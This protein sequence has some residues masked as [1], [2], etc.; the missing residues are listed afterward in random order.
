MCTAAPQVQQA[1]CEPNCCCC[2]FSVSRSQQAKA[3]A[4]SLP[5]KPPPAEPACWTS[6]CG[7]RHLGAQRWPPRCCG[8]RRCWAPLPGRAPSAL[9]SGLPLV[10]TAKARG[11]LFY[12]VG[13]RSLLASCVVS[14]SAS[15]AAHTHCAP[16]APPRACCPAAAAPVTRPVLQRGALQVVAAEP[17]KEVKKKKLPSPE[18]RALTSEERRK[19]NKGR[20]SAV[21]TRIKKVRCAA[22]GR[23]GQQ[24]AELLR[25]EQEQLRQCMHRAC[26]VVGR[27]AR[28]G[29]WWCWQWRPGNVEPYWIVHAV[30]PW[31]THA[32]MHATVMGLLNRH[33]ASRMLM[34]M[35]AWNG[36]AHVDRRRG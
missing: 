17:G 13:A 15:N 4:A 25:V 28:R 30:C 16:T 31:C 11:R 29:G 34:C 33:A 20:K 3:K 9:P 14:L 2:S 8:R 1:A 18:K 36:H 22:A 23:A 26:A 7:Q 6:A 35:H 5:L 24:A 12:A 10:S 21:A 27:C 32:C 19:Y